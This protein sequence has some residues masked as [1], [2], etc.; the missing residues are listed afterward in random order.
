MYEFVIHQKVPMPGSEPVTVTANSLGSRERSDTSQVLCC[1][2]GG[3]VFGLHSHIASGLLQGTEGLAIS[4][5]RPVLRSPPV[6]R[7]VIHKL[8]QR[9][10][11]FF[12]FRHSYMH[13]IK[14]S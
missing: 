13:G 11:N 4:L 9:R 7:R 8:Q 5:K 3:R 1:A 14:A 6:K 10:S 12:R 2:L